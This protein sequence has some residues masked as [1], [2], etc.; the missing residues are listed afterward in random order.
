MESVRALP[1]RPHPVVSVVLEEHAAGVGLDQIPSVS[2]HGLPGVKTLQGGRRVGSAIACAAGHC[3]NPAPAAAP[4]SRA[5]PRSIDLRVIVGS[6]SQPPAERECALAVRVVSPQSGLGP[7][8]W[9]G[10]DLVQGEFAGRVR[11]GHQ[12]AAPTNHDHL[13]FDPRPVPQR[14]MDASAS[15]VAKGLRCGMSARTSSIQAS[16]A[17]ARRWR[18][19]GRAQARSTL[20]PMSAWRS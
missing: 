4:A 18:M 17:A 3:I 10:Q 9:P 14:V 6:I 2:Y 11:L 8:R 12:G 13:N 7:L 5:P 16:S 1:V 20:S 19:S 15:G